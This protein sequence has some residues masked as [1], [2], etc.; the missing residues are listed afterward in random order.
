MKYKI[1]TCVCGGTWWIVVWN[2][3]L[4]QDQKDNSEQGTCIA[5]DDDGHLIYQAGDLLQARCTSIS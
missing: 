4:Q 5:D 1:L 2:V 3:Y